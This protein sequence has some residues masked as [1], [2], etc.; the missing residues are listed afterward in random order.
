M[1]TKCGKNGQERKISQAIQEELDDLYKFEAKIINFKDY[2][3]HS[4]RSRCLVLGVRKDVHL[5]IDDLWPSK[6]NSK[7][8]RDLIYSLPRLKVMGESYQSDIYHNF[9]PYKSHM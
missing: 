4:S 3:A 8:M 9:K 6:E 1:N 5:N 7:T 2:G